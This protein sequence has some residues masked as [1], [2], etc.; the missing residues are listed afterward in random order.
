VLDWLKPGARAIVQG[1]TGEPLPFIAALKAAPDAAAGVDLWSCLVPGINT[2]DYGSVH[3]KSRFTTF[4]ASP[5]WSASIADGRTQ[6]RAMPYSSIGETLARTDF[7]LAILH[8]SP[9]DDAGMC[10]FGVCCDVG[11]IVWPRAKRRIAYINTSMPRL[12]RADAIPLSAIDLAI[13]VDAP[14]IAAPFNAPSPD[15]AVIGRHV[16]S[17]VP[18]GATIQSGI[19]Q[20]PGAAIAALANHRRLSVHSGLIT[21]DYRVLAEAG[22][23]GADAANVTGIAYGDAGFYRWLA[24]SDFAEFRA[25]P[26]THGAAGLAAAPSFHAI[27]SAIEVDLTGAIN[28]EF[29][30]GR[31][32]SSVGGAPDYVRGALASRGGRSIVALP[33]T[34]RSGASRILPVLRAGETSLPGAMADA[35]VTER[36]VAELRGKSPEAHA[37]A[38]I[39]IAAPE[40]RARLEMASR[41]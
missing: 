22:A 31:R 24:Q 19:G 13:H 5:A 10:S 28:I 2:F 9:P 41:G 14:L 6:L 17:L 1:A 40:H 32:V 15:L 33:S 29:I 20:A 26:E 27:N 30:G 25:I 7:D 11:A 39:A 38:L 4:M 18:D 16:A 8:V 21:A 23:I 34:A 35:I 12:P 36:G 3:E 37:E